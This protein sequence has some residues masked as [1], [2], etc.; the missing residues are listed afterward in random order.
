MGE[1]FPKE[2]IFLSE[3]GQGDWIRIRERKI[4]GNRDMQGKKTKDSVPVV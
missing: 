4:N 2:R 1:D 3:N